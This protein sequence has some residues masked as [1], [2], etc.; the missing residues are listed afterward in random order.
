VIV[1]TLDRLEPH[2]RVE[3]VAVTG[4]IAIDIGME[5]LRAHRTRGR[6]ADLDLVARSVDVVDPG[7]ARDFLV[8]HYHVA[9]PGVPKFM[10]QL[11][12]PATRIR[13]DIFPDLAGS[14]A[15]ACYVS[16][17]AH[18]VRILS[19][20]DILDHKL[21]TLSKASP[22]RPVDPKHLRD[23]RAIARVLGRTIAKIDPRCLAEDVYGETKG[24]CVR[25]ESS[26]RP[27]FPLAQPHKIAALLGWTVNVK[28]P[29]ANRATLRVTRNA[30]NVEPP[31]TWRRRRD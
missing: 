26:R 31:H 3:D 27:E 11:V 14:I 8:S 5:A 17:G 19:L 6:V 1:A 29:A 2:L 12:D 20:E 25:C 22:E 24:G 21:E 28:K 4:G 13:V 7:L 18:Q 10:I 30:C 15:R 16:I 9:G 23:A